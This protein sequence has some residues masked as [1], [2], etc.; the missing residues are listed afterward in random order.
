MID[1]P[2]KCNNSAARTMDSNEVWLE[3]TARDASGRVIGRSGAR[4][5]DGALAPDTHLLRTQPVDGEG[6]PLARRDPQHTRGVAFDAALA[7]S[8]PQVVRFEIPRRAIR[9]EGRL[10]YRKFSPDYARL[11]CADLPERARRRCLD[12][13]VVEVA[14]ATLVAGAPPP[15]RPGARPL[16]RAPGGARDRSGAARALAPPQPRTRR[17]VGALSHPPAG[18]APLSGSHEFNFVARE[19]LKAG[20]APIVP[21]RAAADA[22][23]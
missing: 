21:A 18:G 7:P 16:R 4:G 1:R 20:Q 9:I 22:R 14:A 5:R 15:S 2:A 17:R 23:A 3:I 19:R 11:A 12:L 8:D 13:P 10:L 6:R